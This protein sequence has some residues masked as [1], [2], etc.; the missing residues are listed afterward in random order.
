[1]AFYWISRSLDLSGTAAEVN[2]ITTNLNNALAHNR[3][4]VF[5]YHSEGGNQ[6]FGAHLDAVEA[7]AQDLWIAPFGEVAQYIRQRDAASLEVMDSTSEQ[8]VLSLSQQLSDTSFATALTLVVP[9]PPDWDAP[10]VFQ[11]NEPLASN[12]MEDY[13]FFDAVPGAGDIEIRNVIPTPPPV[14]DNFS[15]QWQQDELHLSF[16]S[17]SGFDY[18][19]ESSMDLSLDSWQPHATPGIQG[20]DEPL[21]FII[22]TDALPPT[23]FFRIKV[24][25]SQ[26]HKE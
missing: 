20:N 5:L 6:N 14:P 24:E 15:I 7:F 9:I 21:S 26:K 13:V 12:R 11:G 23:I 22:P 19:L 3:W 2:A 16:A 1:M 4:S 25:V 10:G 17:V 8:I 18:M